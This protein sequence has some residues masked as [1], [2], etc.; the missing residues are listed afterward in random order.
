MTDEK[1]QFSAIPASAC[2]F[3][4]G[5][6]EFGDNGDGAKSAPIR[7]LARSG[8]PIQHWFWGRVVHD[9]A[10]M[11]LSKPRIAL[12]YVH[13]PKDVIGYANHMTAD[14]N[15]LVL[16][17]ALTPVKENDRASEIIAKAKAGVP[18]EAS[19]NFGGDGI[20]VE[21]VDEGEVA[22]VNGY[23]F[24]GPGVVIREWPL[25]GTAVCPYGADQNTSATFAPG[26][27]FSASV[28]E[29]VKPMEAA[30]ADQT[31]EAVTSAAAT[32]E[33]EPVDATPPEE[34][35]GA[36]PVEDAPVAEEPAPEPESEP[37][38]DASDPRT[39]FA[40]LKE[41]FGAEIA[42]EVF[43][44]GGG[45]AEATKMAMD[46][47]AAEIADLREKLAATSLDVG[48]DPVPPGGNPSANKGQFS[49][50][51]QSKKSKKD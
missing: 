42:A 43:A 39:E 3:A 14:N 9:M 17:G 47:M 20:K 10:G 12:D 2:C 41:E 16:E 50:F 24:A 5:T 34:L 21:Q 35:A 22:F 11:H 48:S 26:D 37:T 44:N 7:L 36:S 6:I 19:I 8:Q 27:T 40:A 49:D 15:G 25:R 31:N 13:D 18:Y 23:E 30:M 38:P 46:N 29:T 4:G 32:P 33:A 1:S 45:H 28:C 51:F